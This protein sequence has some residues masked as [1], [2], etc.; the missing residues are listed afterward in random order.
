[1]SDTSFIRLG[2]APEGSVPFQVVDGAL[3][4]VSKAGVN[5]Q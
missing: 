2:D 4:F 3:C 5:V 1:M